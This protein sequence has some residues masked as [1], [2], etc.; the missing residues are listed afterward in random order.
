MGTAM[1]SRERVKR[2]VLFGRPDRIPFDLPPKW[3]SD[4]L[5]VGAS[6]DPLWSPS[7]SDDMEREDEWGCIWRKIAGDRTMGQVRFH[8]L[9]DYSRLENYR[10]PDYTK[11]ARYEKAVELVANNRE[12]K[13]VLAHVPFSLIHRLEYLRGHQEAWTDWHDHPEEFGRLLDM[14]CDIAVT[15]IERFAELGA[16]GIFSCDDWGVQDRLIIKPEV[17]HRVW[18]PRYRKVYDFAKSRGM[19]TF[20]HSCGHITEILGGLAEAGLNVIQMDQQ[21]NMGL[22]KLAGSFGGKL[23][24][25]CPV[26]IQNTMIKGS[27]RDV[28][29]YAVRLMESFGRF[30]GG[31]I[32][33]WYPAPEAAG[34]SWDKINAMSDTF[35]YYGSDFYSK[36]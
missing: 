25:W 1:T 36:K 19:L 33:K 5:S 30:D 23:C 32:A 35:A 22:E 34:H 18:K 7:V 13:F 4:F 14:M 8:P 28:R 27:V 31:F 17:W 29:N 11:K 24:F 10:F 9:A 21:E 3:G 12:E 20:L 6:P 16:D 2:A 15:A 26:D